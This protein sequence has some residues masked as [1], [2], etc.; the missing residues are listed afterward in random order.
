MLLQL[1]KSNKK[2][3]NK[4]TYRINKEG[5]FYLIGGELVPEKEM[6]AMFPLELRFAPNNPD[7]TKF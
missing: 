3:R 2:A 5:G 1:N 4:F 7:K 6:A